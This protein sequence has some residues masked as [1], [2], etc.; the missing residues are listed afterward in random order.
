MFHIVLVALI[1]T[2]SHNDNELSSKTYLGLPLTNIKGSQSNITK[3]PEKEIYLILQ[4]IYS[5]N[6][7]RIIEENY[8]LHKII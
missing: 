6:L 5:D 7:D 1:S 2:P 4:Q 8:N 3:L